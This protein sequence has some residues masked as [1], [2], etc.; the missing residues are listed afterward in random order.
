MIQFLLTHKVDTEDK[1]VF[2]I[3]DEDCKIPW[4]SHLNGSVEYETEDN[5]GE[6]ITD[7]KKSF[8]EIWAKDS[9]ISL[10]E[11]KWNVNE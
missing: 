7:F 1:I 11:L 8:Q 9:F 3:G 4:S 2:F 6:K 10:G 5:F